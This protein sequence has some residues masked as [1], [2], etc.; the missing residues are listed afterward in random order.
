MPELTHMFA[1]LGDPTRFAI[2][3]R[4]M[5]EGEAAAG[6]ITAGFDLSAPAISRHLAVLHDA[7]LVR[8]RAEA[9]RRIYS[10]NTAAMAGIVQWT[11]T[12]RDF[13]EH[14]IARLEALMQQEET[15]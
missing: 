5:A 10:V 4:L 6:D 12:H 9:Q 15:P 14:S 3:E 8:R 13:W 2:F 11:M 1:A 7:G